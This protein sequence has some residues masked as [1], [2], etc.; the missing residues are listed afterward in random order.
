MKL[1]ADHRSADV[2]LDLEC[3]REAFEAAHAFRAASVRMARALVRIERSGMHLLRGHSGVRDYAMQALGIPGDA[4]TGLIAMGRH[5]DVPATPREDDDLRGQPVDASHGG[6][7][8]PDGREGETEPGLLGEGTTLPTGETPASGAGSAGTCDEDAVPTA[9]T[10]EDRVRDGTLSMANVRAFDRLVTALGGITREEREM[11]T[12]LAE[13]AS[14]WKFGD[15]VRR[16]IEEAA[17]GAPTVALRL[18]VTE[19]ANAHF[20]R[21]RVLLSRQAG[22]ILTDGQVFAAVVGRFVRDQDKLATGEK[23][24]RTPH[25]KLQPGRRYVPAQVERA[26]LRRAE[27]RCEVGD[28]PHDTFLQLM[29]IRTP[30]AL[31][32]AREVEDLAAGC[33]RHHL[34]HDAGVIRFAG[35]DEH[36]RPMF[37]SRDGRLLR[38]SL[39]PERAVAVRRP[40]RPLPCA[41][42]P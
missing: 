36:D 4:A 31:G 5:L 11:W 17:Q 20:R 9:P 41:S 13:T 23:P 30:H 1:Q 27:D 37:R 12:R 2:T 15:L 22:Q 32:G 33:T 24:R 7:D 16:A 35:F 42:E 39:P 28:C 8:S 18:H 29:H 14:E 3:E 21:A 26:V 38:R 6:E 40:E 10:F 34:L 25:T 19:T